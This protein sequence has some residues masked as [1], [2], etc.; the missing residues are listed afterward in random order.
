[1]PRKP[2]D[3]RPDR[4]YIPLPADLPLDRLRSASAIVA[5]PGFGL[6]PM[7]LASLFAN[8]G[9]DAQALSFQVQTQTL[10]L[11]DEG[12]SSAEAA[13]S[14][15]LTA[16]G[17]WGD[18]LSV[19][20]RIPTLSVS[21]TSL[22][23]GQENTGTV[24]ESANATHSAAGGG[25][26][27][28]RGGSGGLSARP[29]G[30]GANAQPLSGRAGAP[31]FF[32]AGFS[33]GASRNGGHGGGAQ[34]PSGSAP[35]SQTT[36]G[37][38]T[39][40]AGLQGATA[41]SQNQ[42]LVSTSGTS[43]SA[44][45]SSQA[46]RAG[47]AT[48][49]N[50]GPQ[51]SPSTSLGPAGLANRSGSTGGQSALG[52]GQTSGLPS[53]GGSSAA[54]AQ[55]GLG[56][57]GKSA[58][59]SAPNEP[60]FAGPTVA[61]SGAG[62]S[63]S[64]ST[65]SLSPFGRSS[66][67]GSQ[68]GA[69]APPS[70][71]P[72]TGR[73][74]PNGG[75]GSSGAPAGAAA[76][77]KPV[78]GG[79]GGIF[80]QAYRFQQ[81]PPYAAPYSSGP[82]VEDAQAPPFITLNALILSYI[83]G[84]L[85][86]IVPFQ[87]TSSPVVTDPPSLSITASDGLGTYTLSASADYEINTTHGHLALFG[88]TVTATFDYSYGEDGDTPD[89]ASFTL[90]DTGGAT[91]SLGS[92]TG[93]G[94]SLTHPLSGTLTGS[95]SYELTQ[96]LA[97]SDAVAGS[98]SSN[99]NS[100]DTVGGSDSF[101]LGETQC[102][103]L[104][105][106][107]SITGGW[108]TYTFN[109]S[110]TDTSSASD[111]ESD[112]VSGVSG[113]SQSD[114]AASGSTGSGGYTF[115]ALGTDTMGSLGFLPAGSNQFTW[116]ESDSEGTST[117]DSASD[118]VTGDV[119]ATDVAT[120]AEALNSSETN[121]ETGSENFSST[122]GSS[123]GWTETVGYAY[124]SSS[125]DVDTGADA[126]SETDSAEAIDTDADGDAFSTS[127]N[128]ADNGTV[129]STL[130]DTG[131]QTLNASQYITGGNSTFTWSQQITDTDTAAETS[132][133]S[134]SST[135]SDSVGF[136]G[137]TITQWADESSSEAETA[138]DASAATDDGI[139][140]SNET[141][142]GNESL[143][144]YG[145]VFSGAVTVTLGGAL[146]DDENATD[147]DADTT[148]WTGGLTDYPAGVQDTDEVSDGEGDQDNLS[149]S[150]TDTSTILSDTTTLTLGGG[151]MVVGSASTEVL[152]N[153]DSSTST[154]TDA[155]TDQGTD[156]D[157]LADGAD[158]DCYSDGETDSVTVVGF[159]GDT[160]TDIESSAVTIGAGYAVTAGYAFSSVADNGAVSSVTTSE[161]DT[162]DASDSSTESVSDGGESDSTSESDTESATDSSAETDVETTSETDTTSLSLGTAGV[163]LSG[164]GYELDTAVD[165]FTE[166]DSDTGGSSDQQT[167]TDS[168]DLGG[169]T[170][171]D[172]LS[173]SEVDTESGSG[174][175]GG[176][177]QSS[178]T[179]NVGYGPGQVVT[180]GTQTE[181]DSDAESL[182]ETVDDTSSDSSPESETDSDIEAAD[183]SSD[184][185]ST[186]ESD[187]DSHHETDGDSSTAGDSETVVLGAGNDVLS[188]NSTS[189]ETDTGDDNSTDADTATTTTSESDSYTDTVGGETTTDQVTGVSTETDAVTDTEN[190]APTNT[191]EST[192]STGPAGILLGGTTQ[193]SLNDVGTDSETADDVEVDSDT[194]TAS[195][196]DDSSADSDFSDDEPD[197]FRE[198]DTLT[199]SCTQP[200][201]LSELSEIDLGAGG[202]I[203]DGA[204]ESVET[205]NG[206]G[207]WSSTTEGADTHTT[208]LLDDELDTGDSTSLGESDVESGTFSSSGTSTSSFDEYD[209]TTEALG[210]IGAVVGGSLTTSVSDSS[211]ASNSASETDGMSESLN[212]HTIDYEE[213]FESDTEPEQESGSYALIDSGSWGTTLIETLAETLA[214][215]GVV[216]TGDESQSIDDTSA[217]TTTETGHP[218]ET[219]TDSASDV[220]TTV[221]TTTALT[222]TANESD[223]DWATESLGT[224][225]TISGGSDCLT[226]S[227]LDESTYSENGS[228]TESSSDTDFGFDE[229]D[230][231]PGSGSL[232]IGGGSGSSSS[233][234][235]Q[236][237]GDILAQGGAI[238]SGSLT[239]TG[240]TSDSDI[241]TT[242]ESGTEDTTD[243][244]TPL[245]TETASYGIT[246]TTA[247]ND[248]ASESG[249]ESLT[250]GGAISGGSASFSWSE[251]DSVNQSLSISGLDAYLDISDS[252]TDSYGFGES[253]TESI[254]TGGADAPGTIGFLWTQMG[255]DDYQ[256]EQ[257]NDVSTPSMSYDV[258]LID[259]ISS[260]WCDAGVDSLTD[261]D[262]L[263]GETDNWTWD[264]SHSLC[265]SATEVLG[266]AGAASG[267]ENPSGSYDQL[268]NIADVGSDTLGTDT[269]ESGS[270]TLDSSGETYTILQSS[271]GY[272]ALDWTVPSIYGGGAVSLFYDTSNSF[273]IS[274][275]G[276][277]GLSGSL[278]SA[279]NS[280]TIDDYY[281]GSDG[282]SASWSTDGGSADAQNAGT[283][284][285]SLQA[286]G[287]NSIASSGTTQSSTSFDYNS[288]DTASGE[289][290]VNG[291]YVRTVDG[292]SHSDPFQYTGTG[293]FF[294]TLAD[295]VWYSE[296]AG[297]TEGS[298]SFVS[299]SES[300]GDLTGSDQDN[301][302]WSSETD[303]S[304]A[305]D[306]LTE[307]GSKALT[308]TWAGETWGDL[309]TSSATEG[310]LPGGDLLDLVYPNPGGG[311]SLIPEN[312]TDTILSS[313]DE[314]LASGLDPVA[315]INILFVDYNP[316]PW[317]FAYLGGTT[318]T[319][320]ATEGSPYTFDSYIVNSYGSSAPDTD[321]ATPNGLPGEEVARLG[322]FAEN[323]ATPD[324]AS[325]SAAPDPTATLVGLAA[326]WRNPA[327]I[328][329]PTLAGSEASGGEGGDA[330]IAGSS[331]STT[332]DNAGASSASGSG[333]STSSASSGNDSQGL[334]D[335][336]PMDD[337]SSGQGSNLTPWAEGI[338]A[339]GASIWENTGGA[340]Y[341]RFVS[342]GE[343]V[344]AGYGAAANAGSNSSIGIGLG[345]IQREQLAN[346]IADP[347][348]QTAATETTVG[349]YQAANARSLGNFVQARVEES[350]AVGEGVVAGVEMGV[351]VYTIVQTGG[352]IRGAAGR[353]AAGRAAAG[354]GAAPTSGLGPAG[355]GATESGGQLT[356]NACG[357]A[358]GQRVLRQ[359]GI[360]VFQSN[361]TQGFYKGLTPKDLAANLNRFK[362][363][364]TGG[365]YYPT[366]QELA[367]LASR[368]SV[369]T[370]LG[371]NPGHFVVVEAIE[372]GVVRFWDP[373]S[374]AIRSEAASSFVEK[375]SGVVFR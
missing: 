332:G 328:T 285:S 100:T 339:F 239:Y 288:L 238:A 119:D 58:A 141:D 228:G 176:S 63:V 60:T 33:G 189:S 144:S 246:T 190:D 168:D 316:S 113:V 8:P 198:T 366:A 237:I 266:D 165:D 263:A 76:M 116:G 146:T 294:G 300:S 267:W 118:A 13:V 92:S 80:A 125:T 172:S 22:A 7:S 134:E 256:I 59:S 117:S 66:G 322:Y 143:G 184:T 89:G 25:A 323:Y 289:R 102:E 259:T 87:T 93:T 245:P 361:L 284:T 203:A 128:D 174:T 362:P 130:R 248:S 96:V 70:S 78:G 227:S 101:T 15:S 302:T 55:L 290:T 372:N 83:D 122:E 46:G 97:Q 345:P 351:D 327:D 17:A 65:T 195:E 318:I 358:C 200:Y 193:D 301:G 344:G 110:G 282:Y 3:P 61:W 30:P 84:A 41:G 188:G 127:T 21:L 293:T 273:S 218:T 103:T 242:T 95:D 325:R 280:Y 20:G 171:S 160:P 81:A 108:D 34:F 35:G 157:T 279:S 317:E 68:S 49:Q 356:K 274:E 104:N 90:S 223:E 135:E 151:G 106:S 330:I 26:M 1:M 370:R 69:S 85:A 365:F 94:T 214:G 229:S 269:S 56:G 4:C 236:T 36:P 75:G 346:Q 162:D 32:G 240:T 262:V 14:Y 231:G 230:I 187:V 42:S 48:V 24:L 252:N 12:S 257:A 126:E 27:R 299:Q 241:Q 9:P 207:S 43:S 109:E 307:V 124:N 6:L 164:T 154:E 287:T 359:E 31:S 341:N 159:E 216:A 335:A 321:S 357:M 204:N 150:D 342:N 161:T 260:S 278:S 296:T 39:N 72:P 114:S 254:T 136:L 139:D 170:T 226:T 140:S 306:M 215:D 211:G 253:G 173:S 156:S 57:S 166:N 186:T 313:I 54:S 337:G 52:L 209:S 5:P 73:S 194:D 354:A 142:A 320:R 305:P 115:H 348:A 133:V 74:A 167:D 145:V 220:T 199:G 123:Y 179:L 175:A 10:T 310:T 148:T 291:V 86:S 120:D 369:I 185:F 364:W 201:T 147:A 264:F 208:T 224:S 213:D 158:T 349:Q 196:A 19:E 308:G 169:N 153:L 205:D 352:A 303:S 40:A 251:G 272:V 138:G 47:H 152:S 314:Q 11:G 244:L 137:F 222:S 38:A 374:N 181:G 363:G 53:L 235:E 155:E 243:E 286:V 23:I 292:E 99:V 297:A 329:I 340:L 29:P 37:Q 283:D 319:D 219:T 183:G 234:F 338:K 16:G 202:V 177:A 45:P 343:K 163:V 105:S 360:E 77:L 71:S 311:P 265:D 249:T 268:Y 295:N 315:A 232:T 225:A 64:G 331:G 182:T 368:G 28:G 250:Q 312:D 277:D 371:G 2:T 281:D 276:C 347:S 131:S 326:G 261:D 18:S 367:G 178:S 217:Q 334:G 62:S 212:D 304:W 336:A 233:L 275:V 210:N 373:A 271:G 88:T 121:G 375:V 191:E 91:L 51:N 309:T 79:G 197:T 112:S 50:F 132:S 206:T 350:Q 355:A 353:I 324:G 192:D 180:G 255:T 258:S 67:S 129:N 333:V 111:L 98:Y 270:M 221:T 298:Y 247:D 82:V 107:G 44:S 149:E